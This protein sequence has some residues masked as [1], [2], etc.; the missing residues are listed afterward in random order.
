[1]TNTLKVKLKPPEHGWYPIVVALGETTIEIDASDVPI[2]PVSELIRAMENCF[3]N[4]LESEAWM[5][6]EPNYYKWQ[7]QPD[8]DSVNLKIHY[9]Q[10]SGSVTRKETLE[11]EYQCTNKELI[12]MLWRSIKDYLSNV[13]GQY[14]ELSAIEQKVK[15]LR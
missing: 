8:G 9:V 6:L 7:F 14:E 10:V 1:M 15:E 2:E 11:L 4:G 5:H 13:N 3:L 12:T